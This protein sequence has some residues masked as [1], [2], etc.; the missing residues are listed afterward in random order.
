MIKGYYRSVL[1]SN[2]IDEY[3][4]NEWQREPRVGISHM[5]WGMRWKLAEAESSDKGAT[6][7]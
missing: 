2:H 6:L 4:P 1:H 5:Y 7:R 3:S